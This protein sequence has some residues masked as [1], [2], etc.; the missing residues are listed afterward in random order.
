MMTSK[1]RKIPQ[2]SPGIRY[3]FDIT[4]G[5]LEYKERRN[6]LQGAYVQLKRVTLALCKRTLMNSKITPIAEHDGVSILSLRVITDCASR[7]F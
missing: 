2:D 7:V 6:N 4:T 5:L 3:T 1:F